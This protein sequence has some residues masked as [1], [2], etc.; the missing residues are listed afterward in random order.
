MGNELRLYQ[1]IPI[2]RRSHIMLIKLGVSLAGTYSECE[3]GTHVHRGTENSSTE[4][5]YLLNNTCS[6]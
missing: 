4:I 5:S 1:Q 6:L 3:M 2:L